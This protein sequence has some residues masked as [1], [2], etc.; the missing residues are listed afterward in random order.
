MAQRERNA[1]DTA[2]AV[3]IVGGGPVG[4]ALA[5]ELGRLGVGCLVVEQ[6][7]GTIDHPRASELNARTMELCRRWG[8]AGAV[9]AA[10][11]PRDFPNAALYLTSF[12]GHALARIVRPWHGED[13][14]FPYGPERPKRCNQLWFDPILAEHVA[15]LPHATLRRRCRFADYEEDAE[16]VTA[17]FD[18]LETGTVGR[19][20]ARYLVACC[21]G[22]SAVPA[23]LGNRLDES[24][25]LSHSINIFFRA[26]EMWAHHDKGPAS[27]NFFVGAD[28]IWAG[29]SAQNGTDL[30]RLT[31]NGSKRFVAPSEI[32]VDENLRR[33][34]GGDFPYEV[35]NVVTW[36]RRSWVA[37][38]FQAGRVF[39]AGDAAHQCS[40]TGGFGLNTGIG[41]AVDI[42]WKL[43][44]AEAGWA[45]P[46]LL[47]SYQAERRPV[48]LRNIAEA[49]RNFERYELPAA[50]A[51]FD[52]T[53]EGAR[54]RRRVGD[55]I[56]ATRSRQ[57]LSDGIALGYRYD[58]SPVCWP[59]GTAAP[60]DSA[61][62]YVPTA[63]PGSRAPH[64][65]LADGRSILD[66][67]GDGFKLLALGAA[68]AETGGLAAAAGARGV[69]LRRAAIADPEIRQLYRADLVLVRPDGTV[70]WRG[71]AEPADAHAVIDRVR[72]AS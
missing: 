50:G 55:E 59:D 8:V 2:V 26:P 48:A 33:M 45:G 37:E 27:L 66:L 23:R 5:A 49:T 28:G 63:R 57:I 38:C 39:L 70:A 65:W 54:V 53:D 43:A 4:L 56:L 69:P 11:V 3:L 21:G 10:G 46:G 72:G 15:R 52:D 44:A 22:G 7:D 9:R 35:L 13:R 34:F 32:D 29:M 12:K 61:S 25:V 16:G 71:D 47:A 24:S 67:F 64:A 19:V 41:D 31:L 18:D 14:D 6:G 51:I 58:P 40:P 17:T 68:P 1:D 36:A 42:A 20:R 62:E 60:P 30:W